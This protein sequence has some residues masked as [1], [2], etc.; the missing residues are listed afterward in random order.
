M[1]PFWVICEIILYEANLLTTLF[2]LWGSGVLKLRNYSLRGN[3]P[4][5]FIFAMGVWSSDLAN[6]ILLVIGH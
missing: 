3:S 5:S 4:N 1:T 6:I 2:S